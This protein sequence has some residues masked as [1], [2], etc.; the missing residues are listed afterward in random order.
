[1]A[2]LTALGLSHTALKTSQQPYG[3]QKK[4]PL[5]GEWLLEVATGPKEIYGAALLLGISLLLAGVAV[6]YRRNREHTP[7]K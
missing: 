6:V 3:N 5:I 1:M 2:E 7:S 4:I